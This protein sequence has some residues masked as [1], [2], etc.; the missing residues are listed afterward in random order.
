MIHFALLILTLTA[1]L[2]FPIGVTIFIALAAAVFSPLFPLAAG[3]ML[4]A[5]YFSPGSYPVPLYSLLGGAATIAAYFVHRFV[6][7]SIMRT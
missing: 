4:D 3:V 2:L 1:P 6:E 7:A 5:L